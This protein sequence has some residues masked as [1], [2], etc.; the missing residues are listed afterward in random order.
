VTNEYAHALG[1]RLRSIRQQQGMSLQAVEEKSQGRWKAVVIG[2]YERGDRAVTVHKLSELAKFYGVPVEELLPGGSQAAPAAMEPPSKLIL[3]L[4]NLH[5]LDEH[6]AAPLARYAQSI[7]SQRGDYNGRV[8]SIRQEDLRTLAVIYE[9][10]P[11][12]L[13]ARLTAWGVL[14]PAPRSDQG[15]GEAADAEGAGTADDSAAN[16]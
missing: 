7:Q 4:T 5:N 15:A 1:A 11:S 12:V 9:E 3:D 10:Q 2:S 13:A 16:A 8:L 14:R 6:D